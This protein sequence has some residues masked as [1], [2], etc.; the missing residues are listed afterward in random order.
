MLV[1]DV[2]IRFV[3]GHG[4]KGAVAFQKVRLARGPTGGDGGRGAS[5]YLEGVSDINALAY[6]SNKKE[7]HADNGKDGKDEQKEYD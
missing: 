4:G 7:V 2:T 5:I 3:A 6:Y 1:D